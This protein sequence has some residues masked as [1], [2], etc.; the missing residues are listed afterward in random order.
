VSVAVIVASLVIAYG[1]GGA[2][3]RYTQFVVLIGYLF[4]GGIL[5]SEVRSSAFSFLLAVPICMGFLVF[6][7]SDPV[8]WYAQYCGDM[9]AR[10][11]R[12]LP[13]D[14]PTAQQIQTIQSVQASMTPGSRALVC[15]ASP[16][17]LDFQRNRLF[18]VDFPRAASPAPGI[19][20]ER[21]VAG[22]VRY[23]RRQGIRYIVYG[24]ADEAGFTDA[25]VESRL[26]LPWFPPWGR[27]LNKQVPIFHRQLMAVGARWPRVY[28]D[29]KTFVVDL[30]G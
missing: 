11:T 5:L 28:D 30:S 22:F 18:I 26:R 19:P 23:L 13:Y 27:A 1:T 12:P 7:P 17:L 15:V 3:P 14:Y 16:F 24:Y 20:D 4:C 21:N 6:R 25:L 9:V 10:I 29:G 2:N 8:K